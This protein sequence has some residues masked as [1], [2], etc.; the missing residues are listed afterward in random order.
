M[1]IKHNQSSTSIPWDL[2]AD[3]SSQ[4]TP[5]PQKRIKSVELYKK[6]HGLTD[7][8]LVV[9][10]HVSI[11]Q[12]ALRRERDKSKESRERDRS[13]EMKESLLSQALEGGPTLTIPTQVILKML[14]YSTFGCNLLKSLLFP[15]QQHSD[16]QSLQA[17]S[18]GEDSNSSDTVASDTPDVQ[19]DG[20]NGSMDHSRTPSFANSFLGLQ[21]LPGLLPGPSGMPDNFGES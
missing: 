1:K 14:V 11:Q 3:D 4:P 21:N 16:L 6:Q 5:P 15:R 13:L 19:M 17:Q 2:I 7:D 9:R 10:D 20:M 12:H 8:Q 18:T